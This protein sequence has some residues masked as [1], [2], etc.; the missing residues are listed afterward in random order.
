LAF[1]TQQNCPKAI[2]HHFPIMVLLHFV[3]SQALPF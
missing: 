2:T 3:E 1:S